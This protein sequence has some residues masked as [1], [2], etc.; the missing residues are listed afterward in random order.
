MNQLCQV[1]NRVNVVVRRGRNQAH[2]RHRITQLADVICDLGA[3][4]LAALTGLG[5]LG[6]LDLDLVCAA[7]I[8]GSHAKTTGG[9]LFDATAQAVASQQVHVDFNGIGT[10]HA[11]EGIALFDGNAFNF[12][13]VTGRV[14]AAF[15]GVAFSPDTVHCDSQGGMCLGG[16]RAE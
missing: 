12:V 5:T 6:H 8:L 15:T 2:T 11:L 9:D 3:G 16:D 4:Q 14:F 10:N 7:Q 1:F 13:A